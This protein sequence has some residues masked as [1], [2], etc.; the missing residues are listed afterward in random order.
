MLTYHVWDEKDRNKFVRSVDKL[1]AE[2]KRYKQKNFNENQDGVKEAIEEYQKM[3][4]ALFQ[5]FSDFFGY[6]QRK[7]LGIPTKR[8]HDQDDELRKAFE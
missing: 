3:H 1:E 6:Q 7:K 5:L 2:I 4:S 8:V